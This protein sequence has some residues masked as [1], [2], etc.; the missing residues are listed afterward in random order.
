MHRPSSGRCWLLVLSAGLLAGLAGFGIGEV[1]PKMFPIS[2][3][4]PPEIR[5][6]R[7]AIEFEGRMGVSRDRSAAVWFRRAGDDSRFNARRR[8][9]TCSAYHQGEAIAA[10]IVG[11]VVGGGAG[12]GM[13][14]VLLP[15]YHATRTAF[16]DADQN[17]DLALALETHGGIWLAVGAAAGLALGIGLGGRARM[18]RAL[19]GGIFGACVGTSIYEFGGASP[20]PT[21]AGFRPMAREMMPRAL[22]HLAVALC[23]AARAPVGRRII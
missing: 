16:P 23:V 10:G 14:T 12:A 13:T 20:V 3:E 1:A 19:I 8:R 7:I 22:A 6:T 11:M 17:N 4:Y 5:G 18:A 21:R 15:I 2:T 9:R